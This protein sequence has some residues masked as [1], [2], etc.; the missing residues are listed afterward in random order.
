MVWYYGFFRRVDGFVEA[1][2][3]WTG[4]LISYQAGDDGD[5]EKG[6]GK[7]TNEL[8]QS[9]A[10]SDTQSIVGGGDTTALINKLGIEDQFSFVSTGGGAM[11]EFIQ[12]R[13]LLGIEALK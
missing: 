8:I 1:G 12:N 7:P 3:P 6:F 9:I 10:D 2:L 13:T 4:Q 5:Y 11:L